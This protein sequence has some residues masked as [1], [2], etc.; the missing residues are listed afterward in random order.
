MRCTVM[1]LERRKVR[2]ALKK[3]GF[4][5]D[6]SGDHI[7]YE[8]V[9]LDGK[10]SRISTHMSHGSRPKDLDSYLVGKMA[11]QCKLTTGEFRKLVNCPMDR[12][13]YEERVRDHL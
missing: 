5:E 9:T 4:E 12:A 1:I 7:V 6:K 13:E 3:K 8:Y 11:G 10:G 2:S